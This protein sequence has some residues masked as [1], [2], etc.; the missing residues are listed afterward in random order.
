LQKIE[1]PLFDLEIRGVGTR[2][3]LITIVESIDPRPYVLD[4]PLSEVVVTNRT[5][6]L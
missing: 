2:E 3:C 5:V 6:K 4:P 1:A